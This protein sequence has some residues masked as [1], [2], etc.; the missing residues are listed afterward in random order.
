MYLTI[1]LFLTWGTYFKS[2]GIIYGL[3]YAVNFGYDLLKSSQNSKKGTEDLVYEVSFA[4]IEQGIQPIDVELNDSQAVFGSQD[5]SMN[6]ADS[7][8]EI[9]EYSMT[10]T[11]YLENHRQN[12]DKAMKAFS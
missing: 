10:V 12:I 8:P 5:N 9:E 6:L 7:E 11:E 2:I 3:Y 4:P 1:F